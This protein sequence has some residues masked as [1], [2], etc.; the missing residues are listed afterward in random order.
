MNL[1][2]NP[3]TPKHNRCESRVNKNHKFTTQTKTQTMTTLTNKLLILT[4]VFIF[5]FLTNAQTSIKGLG[6]SFDVNQK[7]EAW[8][9]A[10]PGDYILNIDGPKA[11]AGIESYY[12]DRPELEKKLIRVRWKG[13]LITISFKKPVKDIGWNKKSL[14]EN[15]NY[16]SIEN[17]YT[18]LDIKD[19]N[20]S[21]QTPVN[22]LS[23]LDGIDFEKV[24]EGVL[25]FKIKWE[26]Y[27]FWGYSTSTSCKEKLE[28][29]RSDGP[30]P[31]ECVCG[32][33]ETKPLLINAKVKIKH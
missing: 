27:S 16:L 2:F 23:S 6:E 28:Q 12:N 14:E 22:T 25:E 1:K 8:Y 30:A 21:P 24:E 20:I 3:H 31:S 13:M 32:Y 17:T 9:K 5:P 7:I 15:F 4:I 19:W 29:Q 10:H 11:T 26:I 18:S 33:R